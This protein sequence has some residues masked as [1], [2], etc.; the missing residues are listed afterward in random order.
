MI[1]NIHSVFSGGTVDGPGI[2]FVVFMQGCPLRCKYCHNPDSWEFGVGEERSVKDLTQ[3]IIKYKNYFGTQGGVT[4]SGGE[5][6]VQIDF[7]TEL[8]KSVKSYGI[9]TAVDTSGFT[10]NENSEE[11]VKKHEELSKY[12]DLY[13]LDIKHIDDDA[14]KDLTGVSNK[15][16]L[17][18]AKWLDKLGKKM[19]IRHVVVDGYTDDNEQLSKLSAFIKTLNNV[20]KIEVLPYHTMGTV[21]YQKMGIKYAL[22][23]VNPP[24]KERI[25]EVKNIL[26]G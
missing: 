3:E 20:E 11:S 1:G 12:V 18:F 13:L 2:R 19:W 4:V 22:E 14:H 10:F 25:I 23:G 8:L 15:N 16:T 9:N 26:K 17:N 6:L 7:V 24:S 5:P 21:K